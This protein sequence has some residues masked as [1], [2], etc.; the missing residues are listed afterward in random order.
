[1]SRFNVKL[2]W[3]NEKETFILLEAIPFKFKGE[4]KEVPVGF[5]TDLASIPS[6]FRSLISKI[7]KHIMP[8]VVHDY[9]YVEQLGKKEADTIFLSLMKDAGV[10]WMKRKLMYRAVNL[11]GFLAYKKNGRK[12]NAS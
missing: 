10:N 4:D 7:G 9:F 3:N 6:L 2:E 11:F 12:K 1:M 8:A 5:E